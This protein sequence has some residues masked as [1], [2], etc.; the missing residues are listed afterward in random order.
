MGSSV[1]WMVV[2]EVAAASEVPVRVELQR[3]AFARAKARVAQ[4]AVALIGAVANAGQK[5]RMK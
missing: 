5:R 3:A 2:L 4:R 1:G